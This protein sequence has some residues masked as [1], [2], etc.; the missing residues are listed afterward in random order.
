[1]VWVFV[2]GLELELITEIRAIGRYTRRLKSNVDFVEHVVV[3]VIFVRAYARLF[4]GINSEANDEKF[5]AIVLV[6]KGVNIGRIGSGIQRNERRIH[7]AAGQGR[8]GQAEPEDQ[9]QAGLSL[10]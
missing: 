8:V 5:L 10:F 6:N 3:E 1:C 4:E 7:V 9:R 2:A